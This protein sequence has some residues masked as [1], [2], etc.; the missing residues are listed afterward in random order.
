[1]KSTWLAVS[2]FSLAAS[3]SYAGTVVCAGTVDV[4]SYHA[5]GSFM[6]QLSSMNTPVF[7]CSADAEWLVAGTTFKTGPEA[8]KMIYSTLLAA[9]STGKAIANV[10]FDGD[11]VPGSCNTWGDWKA[12]NIRHFL[13]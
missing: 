2:L 6:V 8:C 5:N 9:K 11:Q 10:Y 1:M 7:F 13:Y 3:T 12:A 4:L